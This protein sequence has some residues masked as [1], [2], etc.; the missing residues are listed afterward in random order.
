MCRFKAQISVLSSE[1]IMNLHTLDKNFQIAHINTLQMCNSKNLLNIYYI[2]VQKH[3][4]YIYT[5]QND[6]RI[7]CCMK[8]H[9]SYKACNHGQVRTHSD[10]AH[11]D[12]ISIQLHSGNNGMSH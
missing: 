11:N 5:R 3:R 9:R 10:R 4:I 12:H 1:S 7:V 8:L 2:D 6:R